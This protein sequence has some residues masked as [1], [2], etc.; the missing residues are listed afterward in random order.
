[1][2][3]ITISSA[4]GALLCTVTAYFVRATYN[5]RCKINELRKRGV[6]MPKW[7]WVTGHLLVL[8]NYI[9]GIPPDAAV[10]FAL[11]DLAQNEF[12]DREVFLMD[13][14]PMYPP[15]LVVFGPEICNQVCNKYN[16]P[17]PA[18]ISEAMRPISGGPDLVTMNGEE[19][20]YW[21]SVFNPGFSTGAMAGNVPYII[22]SVRVFREKLVAMIGKGI[23]SLDE[24][25]TQLTTEVI[26]KVTLDD[27]S[28]YQRSPHIL[29]TALR[30]IMDWH[31]FW[32]PRVL[33]NPLRPLVQAYNSRL[34]NSYIRRELEKHFQEA[35]TEALEGSFKK[36]TTSKSVVAL[37]LKAYSEDKRGAR[38]LQNDTL[39]P[40][41]AEYATWQIRVF[42][43]AG[44][45][46]TASTL[47][48]VYHALSKNP[49][50][51]QKLREELDEVFG[52]QHSEMAGILKKNP[53]LL[54]DCK[55]TTAV[56]KETLRLYVPAGTLRDRQS[57]VT[58]TD[59]RGESQPMDYVGANVLHQAL[60]LNPRVW[61]R[62]TEFLPE[63][64]LVG[65]DHELHPYPDAFRP[66]EQ[67]LRNCIGQTLVWNELKIA[68]IM[69]C[70]DLEIRDA[71]HD[72]DA[73]KKREMGSLTRLR[74]RIFGK[75]LE[76]LHGDRA[77]QTDTSGM[78]AADGYP[79]YVDWAK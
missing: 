75:P 61:P 35:K 74:Q 27:D 20:K 23:F 48:Y 18:I 19:W 40:A 12:A 31:S 8:Q 9:N 42:L 49:Q 54:N 6:P 78:H 70:R 4:V 64:F 65:A 33:L 72:F 32:D 28:N 10:A 21:R 17:K 52:P 13:Y 24:F 36:S 67:G 15:Q 76:T 37:A 3:W 63:R 60:H 73:R 14:W 44:T 29:I 1:M 58:I 51:L 2:A 7:N 53:S 77:Y 68:V 55:V 59:L 69:T 34:M 47:V 39:D 22:D 45:D 43:L 16:L 57:G 50:W 38:F 5:H 41:F 66:F 62:A 56:I 11:R 79:C 46:T 71:Y 25:T 30:R 26:L